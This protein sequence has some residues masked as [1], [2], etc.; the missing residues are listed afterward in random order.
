MVNLLLGGAILTLLVA[1]PVSAVFGPIGTSNPNP[2]GGKRANDQPPNSFFAGRSPPF[3]TTGN[4]YPMS[5]TF[6]FLH[7]RRGLVG[8]VCSCGW[9]RVC[10]LFD[11]FSQL[12]MS[13]FEGG[14]QDHFRISQGR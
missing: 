11:T 3:P 8:W 12:T 2:P 9:R 6:L 5:R 10:R 4:S 13:V 1:H 14:Q 7:L